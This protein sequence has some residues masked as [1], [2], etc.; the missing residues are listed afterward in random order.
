MLLDAS[1]NAKQEMRQRL[2]LNTDI[3]QS[4][5]VLR[6]PM[7]ELKELLLQKTYENPLLEEDDFHDKEPVSAEVSESVSS[8]DPEENMIVD[9]IQNDISPLVHPMQCYKENLHS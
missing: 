2:A 6:L 4:L 9:A 1:I 7:Q 8:D 5:E 3:L